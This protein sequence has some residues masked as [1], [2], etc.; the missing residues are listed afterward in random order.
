MRVYLKDKLNVEYIDNFW[1]AL[2][3]ISKGK[4]GIIATRIEI[5]N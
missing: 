5:V 2:D 4:K 3:K 1:D